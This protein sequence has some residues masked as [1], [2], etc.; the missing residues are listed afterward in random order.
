MAVAI[1]CQGPDCDVEFEPQRST[2]KYHSATCRQRAGRARK[3][4][5]AERAAEEKADTSAE[6]GLVKAV[7]KELEDAKAL[8]SVPGQL[9]L[10]F[11]RRM[12]NPEESGLSA[13]SKELRL[14]L[15]EAKTGAAP[16]PAPSTATEDEDDEVKQARRR[17][18]EMTARAAAAAEAEG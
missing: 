2:A 13:M 1:T 8:E 16:P 5:A 17:R 9:A 7:R 14:L 3:A 18:E 12:A 6:H 10:Q 15:A 4:A 11:A